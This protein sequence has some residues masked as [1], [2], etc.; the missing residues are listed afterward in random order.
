MRQRKKDQAKLLLEEVAKSN[1]EQIQRKKE[2]QQREAM[3]EAQIAQYLRNKVRCSTSRSLS[4]TCY[5]LLLL[6]GLVLQ[7]VAEKLLHNHLPLP[8]SVFSTG[9]P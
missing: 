4:L 3:E 5:L 8:I 6:I 1:A 7:L 2:V 9:L